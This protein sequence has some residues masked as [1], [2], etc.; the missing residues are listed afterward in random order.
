MLPYKYFNPEEAK[1]RY[2]KRI[3]QKKRKIGTTE[4]A[5]SLKKYCKYKVAIVR[6]L[7]R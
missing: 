2:C 3:Q 4:K 6:G 1:E 5:Y 7:G